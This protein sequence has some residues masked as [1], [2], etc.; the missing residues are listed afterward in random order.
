MDP[1][2]LPPSKPEPSALLRLAEEWAK[3]LGNETAWGTGQ[4]ADG[5]SVP[6]LALKHGIFILFCEDRA[7]ILALT[8]MAEFP[9][10]GRAQLRRLTEA[11]EGKL[12]AA[13]KAA[14]TQNPRSGFSFFP[15]DF[16]HLFELQR[17]ALEQHLK[18][19]SEDVSTFNRF[20]DAIQELC[21]GMMH[22]GLVVGS[23]M[24]TQ[25]SV[26]PSDMYR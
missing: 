14:L 11:D 9:P 1:T 6:A 18:I 20:A 7:G 12:A 17:L 24:T 10:E 22:A 19:S 16:R 23:V 2:P 21:S 5:T 4:R 26:G 13:L 8:A 15:P 25:T 3:S